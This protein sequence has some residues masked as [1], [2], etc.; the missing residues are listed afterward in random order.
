MAQTRR[1]RFTGFVAWLAWI[2]VHLWF[3]VGFRNRFLVFYNWIYGYLT[4]RRGA[5][6][7]TG[8]RLR[9]GVPRQVIEPS[10][11]ERAAA[12]KGAGPQGERA[13]NPERVVPVTH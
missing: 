8:R 6:L 7:I 12:S 2:F 13:Q 9:P 3:L 11:A 4:Y 5:R 10:E 1:L